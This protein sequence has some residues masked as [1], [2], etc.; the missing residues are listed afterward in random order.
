MPY[1]VSIFR[2]EEYSDCNDIYYPRIRRAKVKSEQRSSMTLEIP[3]KSKDACSTCILYTLYCSEDTGRL[4]TYDQ[5]GYHYS[6]ISV[7]HSLHVQ[8]VWAES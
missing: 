5:D 6:I 4:F 3:F 1:Q 7:Q 2:L 8:S